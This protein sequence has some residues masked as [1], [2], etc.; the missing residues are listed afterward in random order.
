MTVASE[1]NFIVLI[2]LVSA[3]L[4]PLRLFQSSAPLY[5]P[6][7]LTLSQQ[8]LNTQ[9]PIINQWN[10]LFIYISK[11]LLCFIDLSFPL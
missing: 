8:K 6:V 10:F 11:M 9:K 3:S 2:P 5:I 7:I 4:K 1:N